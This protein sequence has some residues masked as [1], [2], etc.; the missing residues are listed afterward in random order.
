MSIKSFCG[1]SLR[2]FS[3]ILLYECLTPPWCRHDFH[4]IILGCRAKCFNIHKDA[5]ER[6]IS[7]AMRWACQK[8]AV[9]TIWLAANTSSSTVLR[10][11]N[12]RA[13]FG[14]Q[15]QIKYHAAS[16]TSV[17]RLEFVRARSPRTPT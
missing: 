10:A 6:D 3:G 5:T 15:L 9:G 8:C 1:V 13:A 16:D 2:S 17:D 12:N 14:K 7:T 4:S 11:F